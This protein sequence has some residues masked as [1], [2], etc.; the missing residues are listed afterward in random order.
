MTII[1]L[2]SLVFIDMSLLV[3]PYLNYQV[4][5]MQI[6]K[7]FYVFEVGA[8]APAPYL[9]SKWWENAK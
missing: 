8:D 3:S 6:Y 7:L 9:F 1:M 4:N 2:Y 5:I